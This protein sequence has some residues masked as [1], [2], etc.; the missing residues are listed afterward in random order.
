MK[1]QIRD[2]SNDQMIITSH[3]NYFFGHSELPKEL[4]LFRTDKFVQTLDLGGKIVNLGFFRACRDFIRQ[5]KRISVQLP[6]EEEALIK[7]FEP[8]VYE[9][10]IK[11]HKDRFD[12][13][14]ITDEPKSKKDKGLVV[15]K[16]ST[17]SKK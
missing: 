2:R 11:Y 12:D 6:K 1:V 13:E 3:H 14:V 9:V 8:E 10:Y 4:D 15:G 16:K 7:E 17:K 5:Y